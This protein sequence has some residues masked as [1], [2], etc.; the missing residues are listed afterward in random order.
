MEGLRP[1]LDPSAGDWLAPRL[2]ADFGA[3]CRTVPRGYPAYAR[4]L[5]PVEAALPGEPSTWAEVC[6]RT[7]RTA[8][9][10]MQW[11]SI[12]TPTAGSQ[13]EVPLSREGRWDQIQVRC[14]ALEP[15]TLGQLLQVLVP[16][17]S[18][19]DCYQ[20][21]WEGWG[22]TTPG[23]GAFGVLSRKGP[24][25]R[26]P[27]PTPAA[28]PEVLTQALRAPRLSLPGRD[29]LLFTG[30]LRAALRMGHQVTDDWFSPQSPN[31]LWPHDR[32]WCLATEID[33]DSTLIGGPAELVEAVLAAPGL[34]AWPVAED[35]D[36]SVRGDHLNA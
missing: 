17:T 31:L 28:P 1:V 24:G 36:L 32:R 16:F 13:P 18:E 33:F 25:P 9:P 8:H 30:P 15:P 5:H 4:V 35:D 22:W 29:Y 2:D 26:P 11:E 3:V 7:G 14:G 21:L 6:R 34:E 20:A 23:R 27:A 19:Q 10:L 12:T